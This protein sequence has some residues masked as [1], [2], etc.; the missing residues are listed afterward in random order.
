M[1][2]NTFPE[3]YLKDTDRVLSL[4]CAYFGG[5]Q[6]IIYIKKAGIKDC[7][8]IDHNEEKLTAMDYPEYTSILGDCF[9]Y[10]DKYINEGKEFDVVIS[11]QWTNQMVII[12]KN[13]LDKL[14]RI[15]KR[16]LIVGCSQE[17]IDKYGMPE[18]ELIKRSEH[19]GGIF[20]RIIKK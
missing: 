17:Y 14:K 10:I 13:Y 1:A 6:D 19:M 18:D 16:I 8:M 3:Q 9:E 15:T 5:K 4:F 2:I 12:N 11:D 20:W 7:I